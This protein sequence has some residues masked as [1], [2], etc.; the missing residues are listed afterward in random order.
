M[1]RYDMG[2]WL[3]NNGCLP[4]GRGCARVRV[5]ACVCALGYDTYACGEV[6][7]VILFSPHFVLKIF[8]FWTYFPLMFLW[9][10]MHACF[11]LGLGFNTNLSL[12]TADNF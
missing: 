4:V 3:L 5:H 1:A 12:Y 2:V 7:S 6:G 9:L 10:C 8:L 11:N